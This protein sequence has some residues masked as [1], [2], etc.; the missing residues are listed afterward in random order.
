MAME[1]RQASPQDLELAWEKNIRDNPDDSRWPAWREQYLKYNQTGQA[2][3]YVAVWNGQIAGEGTLLFSPA[4]GAIGGRTQLADGSTVANV[5]ALRM[6]KAFEGQGH[7]SRLVRLMEEDAR[8]LGYRR[9]TIGVEAKETRN[10]AIY[11]HWGYTKFVLA[12][13]EDGELVLYYEKESKS[14]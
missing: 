5:N 9:L 2:R 14:C 11:L 6:D 3:S 12:Q 8:Q 7:M 10:L 1:Y 4:C 13:V